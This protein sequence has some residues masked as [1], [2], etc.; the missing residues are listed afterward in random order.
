MPGPRRGFSLVELLVVIAIV[1]V[2]TGL[3]LAALQRA[4]E[5]AGRVQC[6]NHLKQLGLALHTYHDTK[7]CLPPG[8]VSSTANITDAEATGFTYL[9]PFLEQDS[10]YQLYHFDQPWWQPDNYQAVGTA[11]PVFF[12]PSNRSQGVIDL[13]QIAAQ[14]STP[15]PP[16]AASCDYAFNKGAN[17][18]L[19]NDWTKTP[20]EVR[21]PFAICKPSDV[22]RGL[23]LED[24]S[25]GTAFTFA[26][27]DAAGGNSRFEV[28]QL[29]N[30]SA[31]AIDVLT[32]KPALMEQSWSATGATNDAHPYYASVFAVTAQ[33]GLPPDPRDEPMN[34]RPGTPTVYGGDNG[35]DNSGGKNFVSGFRS[36]H[37]GGG[38][39]LFCDGS[40]RYV[41]ETIRPDVYRALSTYAGGEPIS[42]GDY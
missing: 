28:G 37:T 15:L 26:I 4:R 19:P 3:V 7:H 10:T 39:F 25:D 33:Y 22:D 35:G 1:G 36:M 38:N 11:V 24:I 20:I 31:V 2:L 12:C 5:A 21:G 32:G 14:W 41:L 17:A 13:G 9:L 6:L 18:S 8:M 40:V 23:R 34:R 16:K 27:G 30:P 29:G 42:A